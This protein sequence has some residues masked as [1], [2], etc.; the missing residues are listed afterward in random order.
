MCN[1]LHLLP[2]LQSSVNID[3]LIGC[4]AMAKFRANMG[5]RLVFAYI[6]QAMLLVCRKG[7]AGVYE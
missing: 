4:W 5:G 2:A 7:E 1:L 6:R 3:G